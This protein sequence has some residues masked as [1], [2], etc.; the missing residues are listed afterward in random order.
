M[1][2]TARMKR[3][4]LQVAFWAVLTTL[5][6]S[7]LLTFVNVSNVEQLSAY[8]DDWNDLSAFREDLESMGVE[9]RSLVSSPLLLADI[10]DPRNTTF[11]IAGMERDTLSL[12]QFDPD[13][14]VRFASEDGY[15]PSEIEAVVQFVEDGGTVVVMEDFGYAGGIA[16][17]FGLNYGGWQLYDTVYATELDY[18]YIWMCVQESPCGMNGTTLDL[19]T[20]TTHPRWGENA[21]EV[22]HP[23]ALIDG[24]TMTLEEAGLCSQHWTSAGGNLGVVE[25][26]ASYRVLLNNATGIEIVPDVRGALREVHVLATTSS[27]ATVDVN[28]D[29]EIWVG[30]E[31]T[32]ETPDLW[33]QFNLSVEACADRSCNPED[34]GRI[35]FFADG[36]M[37]INALYDYS[38]FNDG[39]YGEVEKQIPVNDNR[40]LM[41]DIIAEALDDPTVEGAQASPNAQVIFDESRH[42]QNVLVTEG[43]NTVYFLLVYFTGEGLAMA[44][45]FVGLFLAFE[46]VLLRKRDPQSWRHVFSII[47]YGFGDAERYDY[48]T[49]TEKI[50][51]VL[52]SKVRNQNGLTREEFDALE[53]NELVRLIGDEALASFA[54]KPGRYSLEDTVAL[55]KRIKAWGRA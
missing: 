36:S 30:N 17:A 3:T 20:V 48:Y 38:A 9:T 11:V 37:L 8:D 55:V 44:L 42:G 32:A 1:Q 4:A 39:A 43:Y 45:L 21:E 10:E 35:F 52:L 49:K 6:L 2:M 27:E 51:Q 25:F 31:V 23:C 47:Y 7:V 18:N 34:G 40:R 26:N 28:G 14:L 16:D 50:R 41:L 13:G 12:P 29:G 19:D 46:M 54:V 33:G 24:E 53:V 22:S 5:A 15:S